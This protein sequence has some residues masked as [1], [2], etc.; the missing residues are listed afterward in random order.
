MQDPGDQC[1]DLLPMA[2]EVRWHAAGDGQG[3]QDPAERERAAEEA[4]CRSGTGHGDSQGSPAGKL[5]DP[6]RRRRTVQEVRRRLASALLA[7]LGVQLLKTTLY[8][9]H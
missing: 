3:A 2:A 7:L 5:V 9:E 1:P 8:I 4:G 6:E